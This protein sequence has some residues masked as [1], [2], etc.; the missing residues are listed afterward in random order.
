MCRVREGTLG[1]EIETVYYLGQC[2]LADHAGKKFQI[3]HI[4][5]KNVNIFIITL[6][7]ISGME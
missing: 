4:W 3:K 7:I 6:A 2:K 1:C 5:R